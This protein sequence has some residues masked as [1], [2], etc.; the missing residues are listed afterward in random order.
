[1]SLKYIKNG[2]LQ[3]KRVV[4]ALQQAARDYENGAIIEVRDTLLE[5]VAAIDAFEDG[6]EE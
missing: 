5:I 2:C 6:T 3:D 4:F 1:M